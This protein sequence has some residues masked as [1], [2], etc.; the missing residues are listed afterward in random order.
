MNPQ[1]LFIHEG[2]AD[3]VRDIADADLDRV[4]VVDQLGAVFS[5]LAVHIRDRAPWNR[6]Q[7]FVEL[8]DVGHFIGVD[9]A[10]CGG[11]PR[12]FIVGLY[13]DNVRRAY[14]LADEIRVDTGTHVT[15]TIRR[16]HL[17]HEDVYR[18]D[19]FPEKVGKL[20]VIARHIGNVL[21]IHVFSGG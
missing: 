1:I 4:A 21:L 6:R 13:N 7:R 11:A 3:G 2:F 12:H 18:D 5:D 14:R 19:A 20:V 10:A 15:V 17:D 9:H 16:G 8:H